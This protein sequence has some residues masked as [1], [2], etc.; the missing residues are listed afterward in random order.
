MLRCNPAN[1]MKER[2]LAFLAGGGVDE[3]VCCAKYDYGGGRC[4]EC[5]GHVTETNWI[6][7]IAHR[8]VAW[9]IIFLVVVVAAAAAFVVV[10]ARML[11][12]FRVLRIIGIAVAVVI[13][14]L[15]T[16]FV[17]MCTIIIL[18]G[19]VVYTMSGEVCLHRVGWTALSCKQHGRTLAEWYARGDMLQVWH[20]AQGRMPEQADVRR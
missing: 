18:R 9:I 8:V 20:C 14:W 16:V 15:C 17:I 11:L 10:L 3:L 12:F 5:I 2:G 7:R 19:M 13:I 4:G 6:I 1:E